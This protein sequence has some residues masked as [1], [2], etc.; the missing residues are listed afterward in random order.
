MT[1]QRCL[2]GLSGRD[3]YFIEYQME[4]TTWND[5]P[6]IY[7]FAALAVLGHSIFYIGKCDSFRSRMG[8]HERWAEAKG[9]GAT[10]VLALAMTG[11]ESVR[12]AAERDLIRACNPPLNVHHNTLSDLTKGLGQFGL[13]GLG[14]RGI[15]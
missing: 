10:H 8:Q 4:A 12:D 9:C 11:P 7:A 6:G 5:V 13:A 1:T 3:Y 15:G 14:R 2:T